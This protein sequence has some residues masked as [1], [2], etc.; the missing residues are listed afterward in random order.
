MAKA[1]S[2]KK[3]MKFTKFKIPS[4]FGWTTFNLTPKTK[5]TLL[6]KFVTTT[7]SNTY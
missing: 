4:L 3:F 7:N 1:P 6:F 5:Q 2:L